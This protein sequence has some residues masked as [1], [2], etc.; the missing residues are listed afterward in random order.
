M[1]QSRHTETICYLS[2]FGGKA[3]IHGPPASASSAALLPRISHRAGA[4]VGGGVR[5][6]LAVELGE[7]YDAV[8]EAKLDAFRNQRGIFR[9]RG[10]VDDEACAGK[11]LER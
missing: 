5:G 9:G 3:D 6:K 7:Q 1:A 2:A 10:P 11:R 4:G 8:G